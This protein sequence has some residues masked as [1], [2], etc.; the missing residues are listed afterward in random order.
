MKQVFTLILYLLLTLTINAQTK[1]SIKLYEKGKEFHKQEDY[2]QAIPFYDKAIKASPDYSKSYLWRGFAYYYLKKYDLAMSDFNKLIDLE[3][4]SINYD[5]YYYRGMINQFVLSNKEDA[6][7]DYFKA[8]KLNPNLSDGFYRISILKFE[9]NDLNAS[10]E[11][12]ENALK[13]KQDPTYSELEKKVKNKLGIPIEV[14]IGEQ[15]W[16]SS[17]L[18]V[19]KFRNGDPVPQAKTSDEWFRAQLNKQPV[20]CYYDNNPVNEEKYGKLYNWYA[21]ND[22]RGLAPEGWRIPSEKDWNQLKIYLGGDV[23]PQSKEIQYKEGT[24]VEQVII[25]KP[26]GQ[27][28]TAGSRIFTCG[29]NPLKGGKCNIYREFGE[30]DYR[31][32]R[33]YWWSASSI[34][35]GNKLKA[36]Y[37]S[38]DDYWK[39]MNEYYQECGMGFSVRCVKN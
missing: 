13:L 3:P 26:G 20:W 34:K 1:K 23:A 2:N 31:Q 4:D 39:T 36:F 10:K 25:E 8:T 22:P 33:S 35:E 19:N 9:L 12:I 32:G 7:K 5:V 24:F 21:V 18:N 29:F 6:L 38:V 15:I 27:E 37:I 16:I 11:A 14:V 28:G 30:G 17:N